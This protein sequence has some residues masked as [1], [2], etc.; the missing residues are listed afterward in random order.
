[1]AK[2]VWGLGQEFACQ[3]P[4]GDQKMTCPFCGKPDEQFGE[5][6]YERHKIEYLRRIAKALEQLAELVGRKVEGP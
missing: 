4:L 3:M 1:M 5:S 6:H 2:A